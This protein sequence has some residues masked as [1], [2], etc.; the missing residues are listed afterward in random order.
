MNAESAFLLKCLAVF[1]SLYICYPL[2]VFGFDGLGHVGGFRKM[3]ST[4]FI[5][6]YQIYYVVFRAVGPMASWTVCVLTAQRQDEIEAGK[7]F[8]QIRPLNTIARNSLTCT[9]PAFRYFGL[10]SLQKADG[11]G[12]RKVKV[13]MAALTVV[14]VMTD[15]PYWFCFKVNYDSQEYAEQKTVSN[16]LFMLRRFWCGYMMTAHDKLNLFVFQIK[17]FQCSFGAIHKV[18][19]TTLASDKALKEYYYGVKLL[20]VNLLPVL[21]LALIT[22]IFISFLLRRKQERIMVLS[23]TDENSRKLDNLTLCLVSV[24]VSFLCLISPHVVYSVMV[25]VDFMPCVVM[26]MSYVTIYLS[27]INSSVNFFIY[28]F[29]L[30]PF[31]AAVKRSVRVCGGQQATEAM[32]QPLSQSVTAGTS[33]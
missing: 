23:Q 29:C 30:P 31:R 32:H 8:S 21:L 25:R 12:L 13:I 7:Y 9:V 10:R 16:A 28:Y 1:D 22:V 5:Y 20:L 6:I 26:Q 3:L 17:Q 15:A 33:C 27:I 14:S 19:S 2:L 11:H 18:L 24:A 4:P